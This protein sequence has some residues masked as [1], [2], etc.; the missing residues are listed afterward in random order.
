MKKNKGIKETEVRSGVY[1]M[2]IKTEDL[3]VRG[4]SHRERLQIAVREF[5]RSSQKMEKQYAK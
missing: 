3:K 4:N 2:E 1:V 5:V